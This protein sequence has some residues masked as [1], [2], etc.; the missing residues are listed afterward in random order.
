VTTYRD[1]Q[2]AVV[3]RRAFRILKFKPDLRRC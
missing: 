1:E 2:G 3:G